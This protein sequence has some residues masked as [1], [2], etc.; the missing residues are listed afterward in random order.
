MPVADYSDELDDVVAAASI[1]PNCDSLAFAYGS[2]DVNR[3]DSESWDFLCPRCGT[4][5]A[6]PESELVF[7]SLSKKWLSAA[8]YAA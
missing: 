6:M 1:C 8:M 4:G 5:F 3:E 2:T 7:L